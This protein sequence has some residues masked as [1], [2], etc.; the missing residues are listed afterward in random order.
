MKGR[1][2]YMSIILFG[3]KKRVLLDLCTNWAN[4]NISESRIP[5]ASVLIVDL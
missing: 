1:K 4:F 3:G 2:V 5:E